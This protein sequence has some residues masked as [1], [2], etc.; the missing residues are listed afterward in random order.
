MIALVNRVLGTQ[1]IALTELSRLR[2]NEYVSGVST[3]MTVRPDV[4]EGT[5]S[6]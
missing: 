3:P 5:R 6:F 2:Q 1:M 4:G